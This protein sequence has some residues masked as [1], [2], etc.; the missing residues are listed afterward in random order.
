[1]KDETRLRK[2]RALNYLYGL[3]DTAIDYTEW[4]DDFNIDEEEQIMINREVEKYSKQIKNFIEKKA[5]Q[6]GYTFKEEKVE[7]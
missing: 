2:I 3:I 1:M 4:M 6:L 5:N 7:R